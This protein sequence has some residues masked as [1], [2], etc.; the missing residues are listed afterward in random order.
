M[1]LF[2]KTKT[3]DP[4]EEEEEEDG[5]GAADEDD[6]D[7]GD[8]L[9]ALA[10]AA[11]LQDGA[12]GDA[13]VRALRQEV[14]LAVEAGL[15]EDQMFPLFEDLYSAGNARRAATGSAMPLGT[16]RELLVQLGAT[17]VPSLPAERW[18]RVV[19]EVTAEAEEEDPVQ[20]ECL[21]Q[22]AQ[23][24]KYC[25]RLMKL[26]RKM[27]SKMPAAGGGG[28]AAA[29]GGSSTSCGS[30]AAS[31]SAAGSGASAASGAGTDRSLGPVEP[32][33]RDRGARQSGVPTGRRRGGGRG[34][35]RGQGVDEDEED[36][37]R[38]PSSAEPAL[39]R[40]AA[41]RAQKDDPA[42]AARRNLEKD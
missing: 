36:E 19:A 29:A 24:I 1:K 26:A 11:L 17:T 8:E 41:A 38:P 35:G 27:R 7:E 18:G 21:V 28:A 10:Q 6:E 40:P 9:H 14:L 31:S 25:R 4:E 39:G 13:R 22:P 34:R 16:C 20:G 2:G 23:W 32:E 30:S 15:G 3:P 42:G 12:D 33:A 37:A 5:E